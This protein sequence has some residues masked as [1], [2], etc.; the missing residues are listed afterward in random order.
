MAY[1]IDLP[2]SAQRHWNDGRR[3]LDAGR[4]QAAGYHFGFAAECAVKS[5]LYKHNIP[6][7]ADRH[8]DPYWAHFPALRTILIRD[9][10]GRLS[11]KLYDVIAKD[12]FMQEWD[13]D[14]RYAAN[15]SVNEQRASRWRDQANEL[16]GLVFY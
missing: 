11:Q 14:I 15:G 3:L 9:G 13:T 8:Q 12:S 2:A 10:K 7:H 16:I 4:A 1:R 6:R 5:V